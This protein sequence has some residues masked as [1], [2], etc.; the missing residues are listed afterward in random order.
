M[1]QGREGCVHQPVALEGGAAAKRL[2]HEAH[3]EMTA[4][5]CTGVAG[6]ARAVIDDLEARGRERSLQRP[7]QLADEGLVHGERA[8]DSAATGVP[9]LV[10]QN[11][12]AAVK[13]KVSTVSPKSLKF[14]QVA[15]LA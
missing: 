6:V 4:A 11:T 2:G 1:H 3:P 10:I 12:C 8:W 9:W 15:S 5:A 13:A 7:A 14:T